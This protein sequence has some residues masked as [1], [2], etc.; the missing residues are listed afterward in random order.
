MEGIQSS[1]LTFFKANKGLGLGLTQPCTEL[2]DGPPEDGPQLLDA[3]R[4]R[5]R[6]PAGFGM[7]ELKAHA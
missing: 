3:E 1:K 2:W 5:R 7:M 6:A 4:G